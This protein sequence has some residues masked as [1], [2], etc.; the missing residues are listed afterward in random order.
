MTCQIIFLALHTE[1]FLH[2]QGPMSDSTISLISRAD[3]QLP[4]SVHISILCCTIFFLKICNRKTIRIIT[5]M[6]LGTSR[7]DSSPE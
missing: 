5:E 2:F 7:Q 6:V 1:F 4:A 3:L